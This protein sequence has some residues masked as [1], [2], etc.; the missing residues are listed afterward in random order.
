M[1]HTLILVLSAIKH[2]Y[3]AMLE[4]AMATW[5]SIDHPNTTTLY[6]VGNCGTPGP[7]VFC[8]AYD[9]G[10]MNIGRRTIE[11]FGH[12]LTIP[13]WTHLAR[14]HSSCYVHKW[15]LVEYVNDLPGASVMYGLPAKSNA[16]PGT[17]Y[18]TGCG[19]YIFSRD[20]ISRLVEH[21]HAWDHSIM[22]DE[23]VSKLARSIGI[24]FGNLRTCSIDRIDGSWACI[25]YHSA[26][27][28][29]KFEDFGSMDKADQFFFRVKQD[30]QRHID[31]ELMDLLFKHL[32]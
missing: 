13:G 6:Y 28:S 9:E 24:P 3:G 29:F 2:P 16:N 12:A 15:K 23:A 18:L 19:H 20:V 25:S 1:K 21:K 26:F 8:S 11:A 32:T 7:K 31:L 4:K 30:L 27:S 17:T 10:L 22:E 14:P 5:D